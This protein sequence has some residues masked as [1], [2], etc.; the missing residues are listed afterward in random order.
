LKVNIDHKIPLFEGKYMLKQDEWFSS[1]K[2]YFQANNF[3][4]DM[5]K[6][7]LENNENVPHFYL[8]WWE[9]HNQ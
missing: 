3:D 4:S 9:A 6:F 1:L 7:I 5:E 8:A 2:I